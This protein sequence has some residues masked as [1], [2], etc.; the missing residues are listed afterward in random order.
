MPVQVRPSA[1][2]MDGIAHN[3]VMPFFRLPCEA[4]KPGPLKEE[5]VTPIEG[6]T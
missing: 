6:K 3:R 5:G 2:F 4:G 1:P